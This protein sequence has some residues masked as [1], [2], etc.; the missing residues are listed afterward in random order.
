MPNPEHLAKLKEGVKAWN[1][2]RWS[3]SNISIKADLCDA[4]LSKADLSEGNPF[5][6]DLSGAC[7]LPVIARAKSRPFPA[8]SIVSPQRPRNTVTARGTVGNEGKLCSPI[9]L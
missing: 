2:W 4:N 5:D 3:I 6:A 7:E 9:R 8:K 1:Q